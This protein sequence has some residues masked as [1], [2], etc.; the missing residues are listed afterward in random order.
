MKG[1]KNIPKIRKTG[2]KYPQ[3]SYAAVLHACNPIVMD[4]FATCD[5]KTQDICSQ[6]WRSFFKETFLPRLFFVKYKYLPPVIVTLSTIPFK[7]AGMDL[8]N[9]VISDNETFLIS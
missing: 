7:K 8:Q 2:E 9:P 1:E 3:G 6:E 4:I 5:K